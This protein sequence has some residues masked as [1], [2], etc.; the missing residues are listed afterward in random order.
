MITLPTSGT[1][2]PVYTDMANGFTIS[3]PIG[4]VS[5]GAFGIGC[6]AN[7]SRSGFEES[8]RLVI[9]FFDSSGAPSTASNV[10]IVLSGAGVSGNVVIAVDDGP[11]GAPVP[12]T[13]G[14]PIAIGQNG[15]HKIDVSVP[16]PDSARVYWAELVFDHDCL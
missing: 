9:E 13:T 8:D 16:D 10:S 4:N 14:Q 7:G 2:M 5:F 1:D 11:A 15:V 6:D 3:A 12:A